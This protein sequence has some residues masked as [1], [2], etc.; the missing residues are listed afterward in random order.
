V[1]AAPGMSDTRSRVLASFVW[2]SREPASE[3]PEEIPLIG[4]PGNH[5]YHDMLDGFARQFRP[6]TSGEGNPA[7]K[8]DQRPQLKL[9]G[10]F[11][12]QQSSYQA[13]DLPF[14]WTLWVVDAEREIDTRQI[15]YFRPPDAHAP[16]K[17]IVVTSRPAITYGVVED[18]KVSLSRTPAANAERRSDSPRP[19]RMLSPKTINNV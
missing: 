15:Q 18:L 16:E 7:Q 6:P 13:V 12:V 9:P 3:C 1:R 17:L 10:Y 11:R 2:A 19:D 4:I 5:D 14:G 8:D